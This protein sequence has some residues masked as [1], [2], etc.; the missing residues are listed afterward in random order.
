MKVESLAIPEVLLLT[1]R[2]HRDD[3]GLF[4]EAWNARAFESAGVVANWVQDNISE[5][6]RGVLRG[7]HCQVQ[8]SQ[9]KL[10]RC[11]TGMVF[12]V[13][14]DVRAN[15]ATFGKWCGAQLDAE[16]HTAM[17][18]PPGFAHGYYVLSE[19]ASMHY[20]VT[21]YYA[22]EHER[23]LRW[24]DPDVGIA[25]PLVDG[26]APVLAEKDLRGE[27]LAVARGWFL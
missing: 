14:V 26:A 1:P 7:L 13:V 16:T 23:C 2:V 3:R 20:K 11:T 10:V 24:D 25:W 5:S 17:W 9:G 8:Q 15:S 12:D 6:V 4:L 22:P 19:R 27:S 18:I 21:D